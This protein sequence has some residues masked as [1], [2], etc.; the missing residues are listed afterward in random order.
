VHAGAL[1]EISRF[2]RVRALVATNAFHHMGLPQ[3][4]ARFPDDAVFAPA[5][6]IA[7]VE[8]KTGIKGIRPVSEAADLAGAEVE[9]TD[10][11]H[12]RTG[13]ALIRVRTGRGLVWYVTDVVFNLRELPVQAL[14]RLAFR[15][16]RS[17][18]GLRFNNIAALF[19]MKNKRALKRWL[20]SEV[21]RAPPRWLI[22][23]HGDI[24]DLGPR[25]ERL[26]PLFE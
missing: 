24:L 20:A 5:Q 8:R 13:E 19:M 9:L 14:P 18:P 10:L 4:K 25:A 1:D 3:W 6:S 7:R 26:R 15:L 11:P 21:D 22:P 16:S 23:A 2:G 12:Y 17:G